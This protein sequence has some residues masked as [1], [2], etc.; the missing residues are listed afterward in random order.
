[1][2]QKNYNFKKLT[3][4]KDITQMNFKQKLKNNEIKF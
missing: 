1:M 4:I 3:E 2:I